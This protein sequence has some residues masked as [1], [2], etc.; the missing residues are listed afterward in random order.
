MA[1]DHYRLP[2]PVGPL[3][4]VELGATRRSSVETVRAF[5]CSRQST[6]WLELLAMLCLGL[7]A[8]AV[9]LPYLWTVPSLADEASQLVPALDMYESGSWGLAGTGGTPYLATFY[10]LALAMLFA[11][12]G[13]GLYLPRL[14]D[15]AQAAATV[16]LVYI[17]TREL[18]R[19]LGR[20]RLEDAF[21]VPRLAGLVAAGLLV[22]SAA[23]VMITSHQGG[24]VSFAPLLTL[25]ALFA[26]ERAL[27]ARDGRWLVAGGALFGLALQTHPSVLTLLPGVVFAIWWQGRALLKSR[28][29][30]LGVLALLGMCAHLIA[31]VSRANLELAVLTRGSLLPGGRSP[32]GTVY[33]DAI[34]SALVSLWRLLA[35]QIGSQA[36]AEE[37]LHDP[38]T[39]PVVALALLG[40]L[41]LVL[42][43]RPLLPLAALSCLVILPYFVAPYDPSVSDRLLMPIVVIGLVGA[44]VGAGLLVPAVTG[45]GS[46][47]RLTLGVVLSGLVL[48]PAG[49]LRSYYGDPSASERRGDSLLLALQ[50]VFDERRYDQVVLLDENLTRIKL[51]AGGH[52]L[53]SLRYLLTVSGVP[54]RTIRVSSDALIAETV[55]G[56]ALVIVEGGSLRAADAGARLEPLLDAWIVPASRTGGSLMVFRAER[57]P[58]IEAWAEAVSASAP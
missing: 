38:V 41:V 30:L 55:A 5:V 20:R 51:G 7:A 27:G 48:A 24:G 21:V 3:P 22:T 12:V 52:A 23:H 37:L 4:G 1:A 34:V 32:G 45:R 50:P 42:R 6:R 58:A 15:V 2:R 43:G 29:M 11:A 44:G 25:A 35:G 19:P 16:P 17:L 14:V 39:W 18:C 46:I 10:D 33:L 8:L 31:Q 9:R 54:T 47:P 26:V 13:P 28:W 49:G 40:V 36:A 57:L 56:R 53:E